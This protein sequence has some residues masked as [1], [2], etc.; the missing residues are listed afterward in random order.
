MPESEM[1]ESAPTRTVTGGLSG[2]GREAAGAPAGAAPPAAGGAGA[3]ARA[4]G[5]AAAGPVGGAA[6]GAAAWQAPRTT[7]RPAQPRHAAG[8]I[9]LLLGGHSGTGHLASPD[10]WPCD[11]EYRERRSLGPCVSAQSACGARRRAGRPRCRG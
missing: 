5:A 1:L 8:I 3:A 4:V 9:D 10:S 2:A 11:A 6:G 7:S